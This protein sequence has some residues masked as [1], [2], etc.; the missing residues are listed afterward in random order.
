[1][2]LVAHSAPFTE[3]IAQRRARPSPDSRGAC[4]CFQTVKSLVSFLGTATFC[5]FT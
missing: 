4:H 2:M 3:D 5:S 1:M